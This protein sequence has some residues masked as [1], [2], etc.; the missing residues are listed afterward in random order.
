[1]RATTIMLSLASLLLTGAFSISL[2]Q[3]AQP[4]GAQPVPWHPCAQI[5]AACTRAGFV[6]KGANMGVGIALDCI[7]PIMVGTPQRKQ[8]SKPLPL[9]DPQVVAA[10]KERNPDFGMGG[11]QPLFSRIAQ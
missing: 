11:G 8:A 4:A 9:L 1:M 5:R 6:P 2:T 7:Q 10:C 3:P